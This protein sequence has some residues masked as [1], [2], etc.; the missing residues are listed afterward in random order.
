MT[1]RGVLWTALGAVIGLIALVLVVVLPA[2]EDP[3]EDASVLG[4]S[5]TALP[6]LGG[7]PPGASPA[8]AAEPSASQANPTVTGT[9]SLAAGIGPIRRTLPM[10]A[11][12]FTISD[13]FGSR[14]GGHRG[15]DMAASDG[16][17]IFSVAD[18]RVVAAG[19]ASGFG[20]WIVVDSVDTNGRSYSAV[21]GHMWDHGVLVRVGESV[22][23]GQQIGMVG[24]AGESSGPHLH[25][26]IV[27]GGRFTGGR[28]IDPLPW[29]DGAPTP[30]LGGAQW[31]SADPRCQRGFGSAGGA[32]AA[33]KVPQELEIWYRRAGSLCPQITSSLLAAQGRQESGFRRGLTSPAGAQGLAQFLPG[34]AAAIN[35]DDGRPYVIDADGNGVASVWDDGDAIIGQGRY[36]C[37]IA[38]KVGQWVSEG[39]VQGDVTALTLAAYNAGEGAVLASGGMP[40]QYAAHYSETRPYVANILAMEPQYRAPGSTGRFSPQEGSGG[41]QILEA[42][43]DWLGTPYVWGGGGPQGPTG[44]GMDGPGLTAAAVFAASSGA[45]TLPRTA[46]QQWEAGVEVP[47][48]KARPGDLVFSSFGPRGPAEVGIYAGDGRMIQS[49]PGS[50]ARSGGGV[51]EVAVPG[52]ARLRRVL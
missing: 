5:Q 11:G 21:Y 7:D 43:H 19:P 4:P 18:G 1:G 27:P 46:E 45:V 15:V 37:A 9:P 52:D 41:E 24:S 47:M 49:V 13:T 39:R 36:M 12:T 20:N 17:P 38:R 10:A 33:G 8:G 44:G 30:D 16:T 3:C 23:A 40:N 6:P 31:Y 32:L 2:V 34:T 29:L 22:R 42:A 50:D 51:M 35:P 14:N 26:E 25:F 48:S 28:Q